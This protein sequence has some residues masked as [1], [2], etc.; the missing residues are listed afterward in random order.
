VPTAATAISNVE[1]AANELEFT[2][3]VKARVDELVVE[4]G[5][6][7]EDSDTGQDLADMDAFKAE[8]AAVVSA[9]RIDDPDK[10]GDGLTD[11]EILAKVMP[12]VEYD[13]DDPVDVRAIA[14]LAKRAAGAMQTGPNGYTQ[15]RLPKG[16]VLIRKYAF[17]GKDRAKVR[18]TFVT[19][20]HS[21]IMD[22]SFQPVLEKTLKE[23][24]KLN[25]QSAMIVDRVPELAGT[26]R[27]AITSGMKKAS[28][29]AQI[30][31]GGNGS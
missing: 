16:V 4:A 22:H 20:D 27:Q 10:D 26:V 13:E 17:R 15:K 9:H 25:A 23:S 7:E 5:F 28:S 14:T 12:D 8:A 19:G 29:T 30:T 31:A 2:N 11:H 21:I 18:V 3:R 24:V 6:S 1:L